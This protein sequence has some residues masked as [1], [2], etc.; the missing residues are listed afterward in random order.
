MEFLGIHLM[1]EPNALTRRQL[2][3]LLLSVGAMACAA[4]PVMAKDGES[5]E[6]DGEDSSGSGSDDDSDSDSDDDNDDDDS[7][8]GNS[9]KGNGR[10]DAEKIRDAIVSG[11][12]ISL[13]KAMAS[14]RKSNSDRVID[15]RLVSDGSKFD[16]RFKVISEN[17]KVR[18]IKMDAKTGRIRNFLG[19]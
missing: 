6:G 9:G 10:I 14:L 2:L 18:T 1:S 12:A 8:G 17:G 3:A 15:V 5:G 19:M 4:N 11:K 7:G 13:S 16:Y